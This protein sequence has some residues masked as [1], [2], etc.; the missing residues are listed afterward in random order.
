MTAPMLSRRTVLLATG[1]TALTLSTRWAHAA[2]WKGYGNAIVIDGLGGPGSLTAE[3]GAPL[4]EA[5]IK[6]V[7]DSGLTAVLVTI[8]PVGTTAPDEAFKD[9][10]RSMLNMDREIARHPDT[11]VRIRTAADITAAKKA[12]RTGLIYGVQDGVAFETDLDLLADLHLL[13]LRVVQ[14]TYNRRNLLG[15]GCM[16]TANAGLS[17]TGIE[18]IERLNSLGMLVDLSHCGR[19]T[20][21]DAI[22]ASKQP[23]AFTHTGAAAVADHPRHRTDAELRAVADKGGVSGVFVMPY[24]AGGKQ[25]TGA[26]V[27]RH[28]EHMINVAGEDHVSI[29]TD[30]TVSPA[31][32]DQKYK[33]AFADTTRKRKE[34]GIAAPGET[35]D[36]YLFAN[37]LNT[38]NRLDTLAQMLA[39]RGHSSTRIEKIL[40]RNLLRVFSEVWRG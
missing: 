9:A 10:V 26:D 27:V 3:P 17:R 29:G 12:K 28:L 7:R 15:D 38:P 36:G 14:P 40:G 8:G 31:V 20:S 33:D 32:I 34:A 6:D 1:A 24:L 39:D 23:V 21:A 13:G 30:G 22:R 5:H 25:P 19:Q 4:T 2:P 37:D 16:E 35:E 18:A 11:F